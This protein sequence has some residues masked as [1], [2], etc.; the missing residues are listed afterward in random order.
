MTRFGWITTSATML[1]VGAIILIVLVL[2]NHQAAPVPVSTIASSTLPLIDPS[3]LSIYTSGTYGFSFFYPA[4]AT[5]TD[6]FSNS[7]SSSNSGLLW[8]ENPIAIGTLI[9]R[10]AVGGGEARVGTS[11]SA[12]EVTS[13]LKP[14]PAEQTLG[15]TS[16][17]S[18]TWKAFSFDKLG[19][20]AEQHVLSYRTLHDHACFALETF[21]SSTDVSTT[22]Q[23]ALNG[24][25]QSFTFA[26]I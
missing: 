14:G 21:E 11:A 18:T 8:R 15:D 3:T 7:T 6:Q 5:V 22:T 9:S 13:C 23:S 26:H 24:I 4:T 2:T 17:G 16:I 12:K 20:D 10:I 25:V 19:T 1:L